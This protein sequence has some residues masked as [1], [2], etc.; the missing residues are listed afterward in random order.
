MVPR[1]TPL[2]TLPMCPSTRRSRHLAVVLPRLFVGPT[3]VS[4]AVC[5]GTCPCAP[6]PP[7]LS[8]SPAHR[9]PPPQVIT[10]CMRRLVESYELRGVRALR[11]KAALSPAALVPLA[12]IGWWQLVMSGESNTHDALREHALFVML[13]HL[14]GL[15]GRL[16]AS[17]PATKAAEALP[18]LAVA[19]QVLCRACN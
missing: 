1:S 5:A 17:A 13:T 7:P 14:Y 10:L 16:P 15:V 8:R 4:G 6:P 11:R 3:C 2:L 18:R 12:T 9:T 19:A